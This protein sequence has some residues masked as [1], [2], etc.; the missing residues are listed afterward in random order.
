MDLVNFPTFWWLLSTDLPMREFN[1]T[2]VPASHETNFTQLSPTMDSS[3]V[4]G[5][6]T[7]LVELSRIFILFYFFR[8]KNIILRAWMSCLHV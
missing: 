6:L 4:I 2:C 5:K 8:I 1:I 7:C 3:D